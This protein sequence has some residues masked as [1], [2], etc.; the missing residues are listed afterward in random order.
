MSESYKFRLQEYNR[1]K[2]YWFRTD[3]S[4]EICVSFV[5][6]KKDF[7]LDEK[8]KKS[9]YKISLSTITEDVKLDLKIRNTVAEIFFHFFN[10]F[11]CCAIYITAVFDGRQD[12]R[13]R[14]FMSWQTKFNEDGYEMINDTYELVET[15][16]P[17]YFSIIFPPKYKYKDEVLNR[18]DKIIEQYKEMRRI[19]NQQ[20]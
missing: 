11:N 13:N 9:I 8:V 15:G 17:V 14:K 7:G 2:N 19:N 6:Y 20:E 12:G 10:T 4:I 18:Y 5:P 16:K 1:E 3:K